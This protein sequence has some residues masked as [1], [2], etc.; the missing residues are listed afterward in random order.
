MPAVPVREAFEHLKGSARV[1]WI[2]GEG[3]FAVRCSGRASDP[4]TEARARFLEAVVRELPHVRLVLGEDES[5]TLEALGC[6]LL[7][8]ERRKEQSPLDRPRWFPWYTWELPTGVDVRR[9]REGIFGPGHYSILAGDPSATEASLP[10]GGSSQ[11]AW[12]D[13]LASTTRVTFFLGAEADD[14]EW[15]VWFRPEGA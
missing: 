14:E 7:S 8:T 13:E 11:R 3:A 9:L 5:A 12:Y 10:R 4:C 2:E 6:R 15:R 1:R